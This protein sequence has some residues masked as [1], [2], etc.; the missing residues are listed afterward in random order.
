MVFFFA[1]VTDA[2][3]PAF[4]HAAPTFADDV[5]VVV[6][7]A[8]LPIFRRPRRSVYVSVIRDSAVL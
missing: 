7:E 4:V 8:P 2:F 3:A 1:T 5:V 6:I